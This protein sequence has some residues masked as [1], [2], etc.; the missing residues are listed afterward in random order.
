L[1]L[2]KLS[3]EK[4]DFFLVSTL[5]LL[6]IITRIPFASKF[7]YHWDSGQFALALDEYDITVHQPH[8]P[9][10]F[11]Y[12]MLG[13]LLHLFIND[14]NTVFV[15]I[16]VVF[17]GLTVIT[18]YYL[19]KEIFDKKIAILA[20]AIALTSPNLWFHGEVALTY[21]VEAFFSTAVA[22]LCWRILKGEHKYIWLS[23]IALG[24]AG[25]IRQNTA[26]FLFPLWLFSVKGVPIRKFIASLGLL[27]VVCLFWFVPMIWLTGGWNAYH[28]AFRELW[29][30]NTGHVS[31]FEQGW[32]TFKI[33]LSSLFKFT[34][35][36]VGIGILILGFAVYSLVRHGR[37]RYLNKTKILFFF[38]WILPSVFFYL[39][40]FI[41][42]ANP[43]YVL[44]FL[45]ALVVLTAVSVVY[46]SAGVRH[47]INMDFSIPMAFLLVI[48]NMLLFFYSKYPVSY[49]EIRNHDRDLSIILSSIK[50]FN[51]LNTIIFTEGY[52]FFSY[53]H[54]MYYL[55]EYRVYS[56]EFRKAPTG[57]IRKT[58][59]GMNRETFLSDEIDL[60]KRIT[61]F[62]ALFVSDDKKKVRGIHGITAKELS[63]YICMA[64]GSISQ[65]KEVYP[66]LK[67]RF[68]GKE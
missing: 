51:P 31:V 30:F 2:S 34:I 26:V 25:G 38:L 37:L 66:E 29:L 36:G 42:P 53:R 47:F 63:P 11:L 55:P 57:E 44:I 12:V 68:Y 15:S 62:A 7:L 48:T 52:I 40:I 59:W 8:P 39:T 28:S 50:T 24:I 20:A 1:K 60:P 35:Y 65:L 19:G 32:A 16:S 13:R 41:H 5:F 4:N 64:S 45:P 67:I 6:T 23:V 43:G 3:K 9:G 56:H 33:F 49:N 58:F 18:I 22:L 14:A 54:I 61:K 21:I 46:I 17:S 27:V 10:Y